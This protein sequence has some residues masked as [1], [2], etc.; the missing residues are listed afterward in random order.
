MRWS[1]L[2]ERLSCRRDVSAVCRG[3]GYGSIDEMFEDARVDAV[4]DRLVADLA[5]VG[6]VGVEV[7]LGV[8]APRIRRAV[9]GR[10]A[11][12]GEDLGEL[13]TAACWE[14]LVRGDLPSRPSRSVVGHARKQVMRQLQRSWRRA[15]ATVPLFADEISLSTTSSRVLSG[16]SSGPVT[17]RTDRPRRAFA[18]AGYEASCSLSPVEVEVESRLG[19][20]ELIRWVIAAAGTDSVTAR[21]VVASRALGVSMDSVAAAEGLAT[22]TA[23][24][25]RQRAEKKIRSA[26]QAGTA[27]LPIT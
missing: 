22:A 6:P 13:V 4:A 20:E 16:V 21:I 5:A 3:L 14:R 27:L 23:H 26:V 17:D 9:R 24:K 15:E 7:A 1:Q 8:L 11:W 19:E 12:T 25:R 10:Q 18:R 2:R